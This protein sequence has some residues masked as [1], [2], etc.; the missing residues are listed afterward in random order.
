VFPLIARCQN[1]PDQL[2]PATLYENICSG[3]YQLAKDAERLIIII[4]MAINGWYCQQEL[5]KF[6]TR[7]T[8]IK[9][10]KENGK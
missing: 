3:D 2:R 4:L 1:Q 9:K 7:L 6:I 8:I 5:Q 10:E